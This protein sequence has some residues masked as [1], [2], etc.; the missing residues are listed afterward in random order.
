MFLRISWR[1]SHLLAF[2]SPMSFHEI[3]LRLMWLPTL[4]F[5]VALSLWAIW[6]LQQTPLL[7]AMAISHFCISP[8][9]MWPP[10]PLR[11]WGSLQTV[12]CKPVISDQQWGTTSFPGMSTPTLTWARLVKSSPHCLRQKWVKHTDLCL[13]P[14]SFY[15]ASCTGRQGGQGTHS[16]CSFPPLTPHPQCC[17]TKFP[18]PD[19]GKLLS[20]LSLSGSSDGEIATGGQEEDWKHICL[21]FP[22][23]YFFCH[24]WHIQWIIFAFF[25]STQ[26]SLCQAFP[27]IFALISNASELDLL[28]K[29]SRNLSKPLHI[30][31]LLNSII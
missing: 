16:L 19:P 10:Q 6:P 18:S 23:I 24:F 15:P 13:D 2:D 12:R 27:L 26:F 21:I 3:C 28:A 7:P 30:V 8:Q 29:W 9:C 11:S 14:L 17:T 22:N 5:P 31:K 25:L 4:I 1:P 20:S